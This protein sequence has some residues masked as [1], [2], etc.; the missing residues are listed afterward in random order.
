MVF[1]TRNRQKWFSIPCLCIVSGST[2]PSKGKPQNRVK[3]QL[4]F[5]YAQRATECYNRTMIRQT[6]LMLFLTSDPFAWESRLTYPSLLLPRK[7]VKLKARRPGSLKILT[8]NISE[9]SQMFLEVF[10]IWF[11]VFQKTQILIQIP[12]YIWK[13]YWY[14]E[15]FGHMQTGYI[16]IHIFNSAVMW[17][18]EKLGPPYGSKICLEMLHF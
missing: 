3:L 5:P 16:Q 6:V 1:K 8:K 9:Y 13:K 17:E 2:L 11:P 10:D 12:K 4:F 14:K 7:P 15:F 18:E